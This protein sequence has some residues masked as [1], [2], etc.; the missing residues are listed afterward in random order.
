VHLNTAVRPP[1]EEFAYAV[2]R[3][4]MEPLARL[5]DPPAEIAAEFSSE[6]SVDTH[7]NEA[8]ILEMLERRPCT[9]DQIC[10]AFSLH[11]NE[12][13][14]YVGKLMR[15]GQAQEKRTGGQIYYKYVGSEERKA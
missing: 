5:F 4:Q 9:L 8:T 2:P 12:A 6:T 3:E 1:C 11:P 13:T 14:K 7:S 10:Q 15:T